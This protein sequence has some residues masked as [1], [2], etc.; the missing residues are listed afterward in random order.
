MHEPWRAFAYLPK[1]VGRSLRGVAV[2]FGS[3]DSAEGNTHSGGSAS[4]QEGLDPC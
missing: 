3:E 2:A 4:T 1:G